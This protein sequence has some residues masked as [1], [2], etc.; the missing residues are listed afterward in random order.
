M[1]KKG[2][3]AAI[4]RCRSLWK[5]EKEE[6]DFSETGLNRFG[7]QLL[8]REDKGS[9]IE[10]FQFI[11]EIYPNS[12]NAWDSLGEAYMAGGNAKLAIESY[13]KSLQLDPANA[14]AVEMLKRLRENK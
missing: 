9:A 11:V 12:A 2:M 1:D 5:S 8:D 6:Y 14:N 4:D 3:A 10:L 7:Y 13:E